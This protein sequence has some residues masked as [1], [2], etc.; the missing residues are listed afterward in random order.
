MHGLCAELIVHE[1]LEV[2]SIGER[3]ARVDSGKHQCHQDQEEQQQQQQQAIS[4]HVLDEQI[5]K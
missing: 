5:S 3:L 2:M 1:N 4:L